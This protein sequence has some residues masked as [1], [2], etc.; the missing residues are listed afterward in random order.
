MIIVNALA[1][2]L[3][4]F[5]ALAAEPADA[6]VQ[7]M[8]GA[9]VALPSDVATVFF[10]PAGIYLQDRIA[11]D[12]TLSFNE[13]RWPENWAF[14]YLKYTRSSQ[15]G[16][17]FGVYRREE[18]LL[19]QGGNAM[20]AILATAYRTPVGIPVGLS[21]KYIN[22]NWAD[23]GRKGY[24]SG[25]AGLIMPYKSFLLGLCFQSFTD[26]DSRLFPIR[27]LLGLSQSLDGR[28]TTAVQIG[29]S[30]WDDLK[31]MDQVEY[32][33]GMDVQLSQAFSLAG[34]WVQT[35]S[36]EKYWTGGVGLHSGMGRARL[37]VTYHWHPAQD[38]DD[39]I[40]VGYSYYL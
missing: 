2:T 39:R 18:A 35:Q 17:G 31:D 27:V 21:L 9:G 4:A 26:P 1:A 6:R 13:W 22:E 8:G 40:F 30:D 32:H 28:I 15:M 5:P 12:L 29:V 24:F 3:V 20:A 16:A 11:L 36:D 23:E 33:L 10:N 38:W 25:D 19:P 7:A 34:G 37:Y 14:S